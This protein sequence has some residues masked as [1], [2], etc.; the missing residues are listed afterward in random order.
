MKKQIRC[1]RT[2]NECSNAVVDTIMG[3]YM[4]TEFVPAFIKGKI[5]DI[6]EIKDTKYY[7]VNEQGG[8]SVFG[9]EYSNFFELM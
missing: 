3:L 2:W 5:Y 4:A 7:I 9:K 8:I 1:I 6:S